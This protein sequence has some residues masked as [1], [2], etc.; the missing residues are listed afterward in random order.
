MIINLKQLNPQL[1]RDLKRQKKPRG[2]RKKISYADITCAFDIE[3]TNIDIIK[4]SVMYVWQFQLG[5]DITIVGRRWGEFKKLIKMINENIDDELTMVIY[6]HNLSFEFQ[7]LKSVLEFDKIFAMDSRKI[8]TATHKHVEFRCSYIHSNMS[9]D[10]YLKTMN[11]KHKKVEGFNYKKKRFWWTRLTPFEM[12]YITHD[13]IGLVEALNYEM[14]KDGDNLYSIPLTSTGYVRREFKQVLGAYKKYIKPMIPNLEVFHALRNCFRGGNTHGNR[15]FSNRIVCGKIAS[16]DISSSYPSVMLTEKFPTKFVKVHPN[17][18][19]QALR[20]G[21]ACLM[22]IELFNVRLKNDEWGCPYLSR[23]KCENII[24][25]EFDNGRILECEYLTTWINEIDFSIIINEYDFDY[26]IKTLFI[27]S[28]QKLPIDFRNHLM[29]MY[30]KKTKLKGGEDTYAYNKYKNMIN[31]VYG[32]TVQNP[33]KP[34]YIFKDGL[35]EIDESETLDVLIE[36]YQKD[37]WLPYQWGV[38]TTSYARLKLEEGLN[39][40]PMDSFLYADTDSIKFIDDGTHQIDKLNK[41]Y[42][43]KELS[44]LDMNG[45]RHY[46]GIYEHEFD[47]TRFITMGAKKYCYEDLDGKLHLTVSGVSKKKGAEELGKIENFKEGFIFKKSG[48]TESI[49]NDKPPMKKFKIGSHEVDIISNI[50]IY[51]ST[52]TLGLSGDYKRLL[53]GLNNTDIRISLHY[54]R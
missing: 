35:L 37:G 32:M 40:I 53:N 50:A 31:S 15:W 24:D 49:Y 47:M 36:K 10:K 12:D 16:Y 1:I 33:C 30:E 41:K 48:G 51:E 14:S 3:T 23:D 26:N 6:V 45:E 7:W 17:M 34:N 28:K 43:H 46:I 54:E 9:L 21:K 11:V 2:N 38:W 25:G 8:L 44:A 42:K 52:Y 5:E 22:N 29:K 39:A 19:S 27:A 18:F 20:F 13:V 4:Q